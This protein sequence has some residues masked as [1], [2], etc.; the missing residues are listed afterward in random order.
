MQNVQCVGGGVVPA[1]G[2]TAVLSR[3]TVTHPRKGCHGSA[4]PYNECAQYNIHPQT[5]AL[6]YRGTAN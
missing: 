4:I 1:G 6:P 5:H 3:A 2:K